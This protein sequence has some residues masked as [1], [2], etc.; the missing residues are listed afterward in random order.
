MSTQIP[1]PIYTYTEGNPCPLGASFRNGG[2]NFSIFSSTATSI[3][4]LLFRTSLDTEPFQV[5]ELNRQD[6]CEFGFWNIF[7]ENLE[8]G[9]YYAYRAYGLNSNINN[10]VL[11]DPYA[12]GIDTTLWNVNDASA[13]NNINNMATS[14]RGCVLNVSDYDWE[15]TKKTSYSA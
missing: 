3:D 4:L 6:N 9:I 1:Q 10:K 8:S 14:M 7:V 5:I 11:I 12:K 13:K 2:V 15:N